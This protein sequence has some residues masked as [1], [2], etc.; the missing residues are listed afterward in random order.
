MDPTS[1]TFEAESPPWCHLVTQSGGCPVGRTHRKVAP[2]VLLLSR[3]LPGPHWANC[4]GQTGEGREEGREAGRVFVVVYLLSCVRLYTTPWTVPCQA[5]LSTEFSRQEY[6]SRLT[7][8]SPGDLPNPG[9]EP[10]S[11]ALAGGFFITEPPRKPRG[12][13]TSTRSYHFLGSVCF[14]GLPLWLSW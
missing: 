11:P 7:F 2:A 13:L 5:S 1:L 9:I 10:A 4:A 3:H 8:P 6:W 14:F 12:C